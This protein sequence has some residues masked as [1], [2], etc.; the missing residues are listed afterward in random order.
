MGFIAWTFEPEV[1]YL[2]CNVF[3]RNGDFSC[4]SLQV[5]AERLHYLR[6]GAGG[7]IAYTCEPDVNYLK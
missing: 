1:I 3:D 5:R 2:K 7:S 4:A 6:L